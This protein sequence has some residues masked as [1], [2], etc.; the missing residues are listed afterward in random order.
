MESI[1]FYDNIYKDNSYSLTA[2]SFET[3]INDTSNCINKIQDMKA[4]EVN[5]LFKD[6][7][8]IIKD[9]K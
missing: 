1:K 2:I 8:I 4:S 3:L 7:E 5:N 6:S 9:I